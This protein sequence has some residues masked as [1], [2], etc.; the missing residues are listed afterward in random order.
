MNVVSQVFFIGK[1]LISLDDDTQSRRVF[2][3]NHTCF[4]FISNQFWLVGLDCIS[5]PNNHRINAF[6]ITFFSDVKV[7]NFNLFLSNFNWAIAVCH[8]IDDWILFL[9]KKKIISHQS[10]SFARSYLNWFV[11]FMIWLWH[12]N[13][14]QRNE[15]KPFNSKTK[16]HEVEMRCLWRMVDRVW[17][18]P[19]N[20][21]DDFCVA[22]C[23]V[24]V[25]C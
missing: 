16:R 9:K 11:R 5:F 23:C 15:T 24:Q 7:Q 3:M 21:C 10:K 25:K 19:D 1:L 18:K 14:N 4:S 13:W 6:F 20:L 12:I 22:W 8:A 2:S 17:G